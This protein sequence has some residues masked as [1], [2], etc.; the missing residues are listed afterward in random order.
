MRGAGITCERLNA[1]HLRRSRPG[2]CAQGLIPP[3][4]SKTFPSHYTIVTGLYPGASRHRLQQHVGRR[5]WRA[6]HDVGAIAKDPR[7]WGGEPLWVTAI[8]QGRRASS[9]FWPGSDVEIGGVRPSD[10]QPFDDNFPN[11]D[12]VKQVLDWLAL[13]EAERPSFITLYFSDVDTAGHTY[14]PARGD[15]GGRRRARRVHRRLVAG[16]EKLGVLT[17][18]QLIVAS[19]HGISPQAIDRKVFIDDYVDLEP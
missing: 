14:G 4:P 8:K 3:F 2:A 6:I 5:D 17:A 13:P 10:W 16:L 19:D 11:G 12:R 15:A 1:P 7:W 9:M 18:D